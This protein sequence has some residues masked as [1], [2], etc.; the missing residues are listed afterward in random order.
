M[1]LMKIFVVG[2]NNTNPENSNVEMLINFFIIAENIK[3]LG[4]IINS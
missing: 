1:N 2:E 4:S 3:K